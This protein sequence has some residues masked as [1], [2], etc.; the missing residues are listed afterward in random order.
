MSIPQNWAFSADCLARF[1]AGLPPSTQAD[2]FRSIRRTQV[3]KSH[4]LLLD[5]L[6]Q[7]FD[8]LYAKPFSN[9]VRESLSGRG[10]P[11][12]VFYPF[13]GPDILFPHLLSPD[14]KSYVLCG[15]EACASSL[16]RPDDGSLLELLPS[17]AACIDHF[18]KHSYFLTEDLR[19][20]EPAGCGSKTLPLL[21][22]FLSRAGRR[23][24]K[25]QPL[26]IKGVEDS[27]PGIWI[28]FQNGETNSNIFYFEQ[29]LRDTHF[30]NGSPL[31][32]FVDEC[33]SCT[34]FSKSASYLPHEPY[35]SNLRELIFRRGSILVQDPSSVPYR[36]L[37]EAGW[38]VDLFGC[39][40]ATLPV[41]NRYEQADLVS[42]YQSSST[43]RLGFGIGYLTDPASASLM[44][45]RRIP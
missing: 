6:F 36:L 34:V 14:A 38:A 8:E 1:L 22:I 33:G 37:E 12:T 23:V 11:A 42:A 13:S 29:D 3:W 39:Y 41:F 26:T 25:V 40:R 20:R 16:D 10:E 44:T 4:A 2:P 19:K 17:A 43:K 35:F 28:E 5:H 9:W 24:H 32:R 15:L 45:A 30:S 7:R 27:V 18:L 21:L 31:F